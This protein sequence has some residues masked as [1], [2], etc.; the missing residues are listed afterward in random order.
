MR[1]LGRGKMI[2]QKE[3]DLPNQSILTRSSKLRSVMTKS[4][5]QNESIMRRAQKA[6][7]HLWLLVIELRGLPK[8]GPSRSKEFITAWK[9]ISSAYHVAK[10]ILEGAYKNNPKER[11]KLEERLSWAVS[12]ALDCIDDVDISEASYI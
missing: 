2:D 9:Q 4:R 5:D 8:E 3:L 6:K 12:H 1:G 10:Q 7:G 11:K